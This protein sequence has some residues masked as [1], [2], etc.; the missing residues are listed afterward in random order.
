MKNPKNNKYLEDKRQIDA[1]EEYAPRIREILR[2]YKK[3][4]QLS[5]IAAR[6]GFHPSR[7]T[8]MITRDAS[9]RYR[10][11]VTPY[12]LAKFIDGGIM[13]VYQILEGHRLDELPER[14][15]LFF[16]RMILPRKTLQLVIEA[17]RRGIDLDRILQE[18]LYPRA[19]EKADQDIAVNAE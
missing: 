8:E 4:R 13:D 2:Q 10:K 15:R 7:L 16:E 14:S 5:A 3:K 9:G 17:K 19:V 6:L 11:Q 18:M 1:L 12:Y